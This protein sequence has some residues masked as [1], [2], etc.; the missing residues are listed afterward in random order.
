MF[1]NVEVNFLGNKYDYQ[2]RN[3]TNG[4]NKDLYNIKDYKFF[5]KDLEEI[6]DDPILYQKFI[7][8]NNK[9]L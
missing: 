9:G 2:V 6:K 5:E 7:E 1:D 4:K 8:L 3:N